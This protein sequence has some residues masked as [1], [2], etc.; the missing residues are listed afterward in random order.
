M[1]VHSRIVT[2]SWQKGQFEITNYCYHYGDRE[3]FLCCTVSEVIGKYINSCS[4]ECTTKVNIRIKHLGSKCMN[5]LKPKLVLNYL[6]I[7]FLPERKHNLMPLQRTMFKEKNYCLLWESYEINKYT[8]WANMQLL[9]FK[10]G[11]TCS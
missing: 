10:A 1:Y 11:G 7:N 6:N 2:L 8:L 9:I 5:P 4:W 3:I